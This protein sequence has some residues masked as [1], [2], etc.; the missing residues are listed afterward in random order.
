MNIISF[1]FINRYSK[2]RRWLTVPRSFR[3]VILPENGVDSEKVVEFDQKL[4]EALEKCS[5]KTSSHTLPIFINVYEKKLE[6]NTPWYLRA[7]L[8]GDSTNLQDL[9]V[10]TCR[11]NEVVKNLNDD[12]PLKNAHDAES[13]D[14]RNSIWVIDL[15][16]CLVFL[17][18]NKNAV[19]R[20]Q[21]NFKV[22][23]E[24]HLVEL[25]PKL[26]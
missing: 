2:T 11:F 5:D 9:S 17:T 25:Q 14:L 21:A 16:G 23:A 10:L 8:I 1:T 20:I 7:L 15:D 12:H 4:F 18:Y 3:D 13:N 22:L 26:I 19:R 6:V 24:Q